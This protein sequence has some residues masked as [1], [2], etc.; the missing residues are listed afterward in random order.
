MTLSYIFTKYIFIILIHIFL[1]VPLTYADDLPLM[2]YY[3]YFSHRFFQ[4]LF[5]FKTYCDLLIFIASS[6]VMG[7]WF[8]TSGSPLTKMCLLTP[9][10]LNMSVD[11]WGGWDPK[12]LSTLSTFLAYKSTGRLVASW[13]V[14]EWNWWGQT[15]VVFCW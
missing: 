5:I 12:S 10:I 3:S 14:V 4:F 9:V 15:F 2:R 1:L 8:F 11:A 13:I 6:S 7:Y